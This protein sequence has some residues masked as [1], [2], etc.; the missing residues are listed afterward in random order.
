MRMKKKLPYNRE[1][2]IRNS[3]SSSITDQF[4]RTFNYIRIAVNENCNLRCIYC[5]PEGKIFFDKSKSKISADE[6]S[7]IIKVSS[8]IGVNKVRF[9]GGEP[10]MHPHIISLVEMA[11]RNPKINS[12]NITTNAVFLKNMV[13]DLHKAGLQGLNISMDTLNAEKYFRITRR[14][15]FNQAIAGL[16]AAKSV[17]I[18][19]IK[20]NVVALRGFNENELSNFT[21]LIKEYPITIRFI[22]LMPFDQLQIW[23]TGRFISANNIKKKLH[24][25]FA[26]IYLS[27]GS[28]TEHTVY[29]IPGYKGK[30]AI[31][32]AFSRNLCTQCNRIRITADGNIRNCLFSCNEVNILSR[33]RKGATDDELKKILI[34]TMWEKKY[35]GF[36]AEKV[37]GKLRHSMSKIGG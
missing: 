20:I 12:V 33:I 34:D 28:K 35:D 11:N 2:E 37:V 29:K 17:G 30:V 18:P 21:E 14:D 22:E 3:Q 6:I 9:T 8:E 16:E 24:Q 19:S 5:M 15:T 36:A 10:L 1:S 26:G 31:I 4:G 23:K 25:K 13:K 27:H 7:R 32:P